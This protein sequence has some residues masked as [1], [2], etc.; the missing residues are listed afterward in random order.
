M[1]KKISR[2][3]FVFASF[4]CACGFISLLSYGSYRLYLL[5][6]DNV[7]L[8]YSLGLILISVILS[9]ISYGFDKKFGQK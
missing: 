4:I 6:A 2:F 5:I 7:W 3:L 8:A 9:T 1:R